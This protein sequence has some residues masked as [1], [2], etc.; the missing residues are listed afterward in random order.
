MGHSGKDMT[1]TKVV[2]AGLKSSPRRSSPD[3]CR[4]LQAPRECGQVR[5]EATQSIGKHLPA[6]LLHL[7]LCP[8]PL[9]EPPIA[10]KQQ[11][12]CRLPNPENRCCKHCRLAPWA[13]DFL[14]QLWYAWW[15]GWF[16]GLGQCI[17][18][19]PSQPEANPLLLEAICQQDR[20]GQLQCVQQVEES[21]GGGVSQE[22][23]S[24]L[25]LGAE[26]FQPASRWTA[27]LGDSSCIYFCDIRGLAAV[28][29]F[30]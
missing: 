13:G 1:C 4:H 20:A 7:D 10:S 28:G 25:H 6:P 2:M 8:A 18:Y 17:D 22:T 26:P 19:T 30:R 14:R 11:D 16:V 15:E 3:K 9:G 21:M 5:W 24:V 12:P 23:A 27:S 29:Y